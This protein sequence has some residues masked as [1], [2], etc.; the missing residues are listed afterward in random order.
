MSDEVHTSATPE[1]IAWAVRWAAGEPPF[2]SDYR[3]QYAGVVARFFAW[4]R[5]QDRLRGLAA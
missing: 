5:V 1:E 3:A 2:D 4:R